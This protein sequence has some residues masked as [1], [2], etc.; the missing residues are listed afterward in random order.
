MAA[1]ADG[2][3]LTHATFHWF[4]VFAGFRSPWLGLSVARRCRTGPLVRY[5]M[6]DGDGYPRQNMKV[7]IMTSASFAVRTEIR[8]LA[9]SALN[10]WPK[11]S[12]LPRRLPDAAAE[13]RPDRRRIYPMAMPCRTFDGDGIRIELF[14]FYRSDLAEMEFSLASHTMMFFPDGI[15]GTCELSDGDGTQRL[16]S[17]APNTIIFNPAREYLRIRIRKAQ[18]QWRALLLTIKPTVLRRLNVGELDIE[19]GKLGRQID[20]EDKGARQALLAI[21]QEIDRPGVNSQLYVDTFLMLVLNRLASCASNA[22]DAHKLKYAKGG[23]PNW[24]LKRALQLL[25]DD[26]SKTHSLSDIAE[27]IRLHPTSFCRA[28]KQS[29]GLSPHR[30]LLAHR[31]DCAKEMMNNHE[32]SLTQIAL[33]CGFS[34]SSQFSVVFKRVVGVSPRQYRRSL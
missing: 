8:A 21:Q 1:H 15:S 11:A 9:P 30:Y 17:A 29:T 10:V 5:F 24:R 14:Q 23:L 26:L 3:R 31:I 19:D 25:E 28:F 12:P 22:A 18:D 6:S 16:W 34:G 13:V 2:S 32:R 27:S 20:V 4:S 33:D 7:T